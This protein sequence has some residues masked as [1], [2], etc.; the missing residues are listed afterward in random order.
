MQP[1][2]CS[3]PAFTR[4]AKHLVNVRVWIEPTMNW[5]HPSSTLFSYIFLLKKKIKKKRSKCV[6]GSTF[7]ATPPLLAAFS[8]YLKSLYGW[9]IQKPADLTRSRSCSTARSLPSIRSENLLTPG[10]SIAPN[11]RCMKPA[12]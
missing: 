12:W 2:V 10:W 3:I 9:I 1:S 11:W 8:D 6:S 4:G 5:L 7:P